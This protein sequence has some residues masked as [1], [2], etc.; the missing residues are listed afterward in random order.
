M[1]L[2][3]TRCFAICLVLALALTSA[4]AGA[5]TALPSPGT[6][7]QIAKLVSTASRIEQLPRNLVPNIYQASADD[8][9]TYYPSTQFGCL[10]IS[11]CQFGTLKSRSTIVLFG[12]SH[13]Q[14]WL[15]S[16]LPIATKFKL[17]LILVWRPSCPAA[18]VTVWNVTT[19]S[20]YAACNAWRAAELRQVHRLDPS[21]VLLAGRNTDIT[22]AGNA[23]IPDATWQAG[24]ER[25]ISSLKSRSTK[26]VVIGD[27]TT[28]S[29]PLPTCL[30]ANPTHIQ[31]CASSDP[32]PKETNHFADDAAAAKA[33]GVLYINPH[34]WL[35][36]AVCSP[37]IGNMVA[38][39]ND[40]H[41]SATYAAY[42]STVW[43]QALRAEL[44]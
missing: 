3:R 12:D 15:T 25:T 30:A 20:T 34:P 16:L 13:A 22:G 2:N 36:T 1:T 14:M 17:R 27:I 4:D 39:Y 5:A 33:M 29:A 11:V 19:N 44:P 23:A 37:V 24:L 32:N 8:V 9:G 42:L 35:C 41:V 40:N 21:L 18:T 31:L 6:A 28:F 26:I 10:T 38:Y 43:L 7:Q